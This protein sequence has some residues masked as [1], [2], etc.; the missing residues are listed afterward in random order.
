MNSTDTASDSAPLGLDRWLDPQVEIERPAELEARMTAQQERIPYLD[1]G[2]PGCRGVERRA[3]DRATFLMI[4]RAFAAVRDA[5]VVEAN[6]AIG[7]YVTTTRPG[8]PPALVGEK[9]GFNDLVLKLLKD[10]HEAWCGFPLQPA[11]CYGFRVYLAGAFLHGHVDRPTTHVI[12][13]SICVAHDLYAPWPIHAVDVDGQPV[14]LDLQPGE[15]MLYESALIEHGRP[16]PLNGRFHA[17]LFVHYQPA[18][19]HELWVED[20]AA[21][22]AKHRS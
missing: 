13:S 4:Q 10:E 2:G 3:V 6:P 7:T 21:W 5:L 16:L 18:I 20:P 14:E 9:E 11:A 22:A 15:M 1:A 19:D 8:L 17:G 12:S